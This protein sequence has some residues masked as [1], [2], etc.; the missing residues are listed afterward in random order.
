MKMRCPL[1]H[2]ALYVLAGCT[3]TAT[4]SYP[5]DWPPIAATTM[6]KCADVS[7]RYFLNA[8]KSAR[9][10]NISGLERL[11]VILLGKFLN[12]H[13]SDAPVDI[14]YLAE[15]GRITLSLSPEANPTK[16]GYSKIEGSVSCQNGWLQANTRA[17]FSSEGTRQT[18]ESSSKLR[19]MEDGSLLVNARRVRSSRTL[20]V[21]GYGDDI[22]TW[23][24]F[25]RVP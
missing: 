25:E 24:V 11:D 22:E 10:T 7:G 12:D 9:P 16:R 1:L 18:I 5:G 19:R 20:F 8:K 6:G 14:A 3:T 15:K 13:D 23:H 17:A 2:L 21:L 4:T